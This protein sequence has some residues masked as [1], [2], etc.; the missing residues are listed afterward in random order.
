MLGEQRIEDE[1]IISEMRTEF[2]FFMDAECKEEKIEFHEIGKGMQVM[3]AFYHVEIMIHFVLVFDKQIGGGRVE[4]NFVQSS[5][6]GGNS[7]CFV[8]FIL[9]RCV[10]NER[11][12]FIG[13]FGILCRGAYRKI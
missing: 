3:I 10:S 6:C 8:Y 13:S 9:L 1:E 12:Y 4:L 11:T 2:I 7:I 5:V